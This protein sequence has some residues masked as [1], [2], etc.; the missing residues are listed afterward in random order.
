MASRLERRLPEVE[1]PRGEG[2]PTE[3]RARSASLRLTARVTPAPSP[4]GQ[5]PPPLA[6]SRSRLKIKT[7]PA[8]SGEGSGGRGRVAPRAA[9]T[10]R[11]LLAGGPA[12]RARW[13]H[14]AGESALPL[15]IT[16]AAP[17]PAAPCG[18][19]RPPAASWRAPLPRRSPRRPGRQ[20]GS[21]RASRRHH[22]PPAGVAPRLT[23]PAA[24]QPP[25]GPPRREPSAAPLA[26]REP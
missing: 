1:W 24:P 6:G 17:P 16:A 2:V 23:R 4:P 15:P 18:C 10:C 20:R 21:Q 3:P 22:R 7:P 11:R 9:L 14:T 5:R 12:G 26:R 19:P 13:H 25:P 8:R